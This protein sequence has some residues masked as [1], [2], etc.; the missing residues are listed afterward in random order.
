LPVGTRLAEEL[1]ANPIGNRR[2][3]SERKTE[4]KSVQKNRAVGAT[5][6]I[7]GGAVLPV[8]AL[9]FVPVPLSNVP[10]ALTIVLRA[11]AYLEKDGVLLCA[12]LLIILVPFLAAVGIAW[13]AASLAAWI[14]GPF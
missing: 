11:F 3:E 1:V 8:G 5:K 9:L 6:R 4:N 12:T 2:R 14:N 10:P 13:Q 7:V